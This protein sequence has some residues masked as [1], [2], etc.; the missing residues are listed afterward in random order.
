MM[1]R[2]LTLITALLLTS[3]GYHLVGH[4]DGSGVIPEDVMTVSIKAT[5]EAAQQMGSLLKRQMAG[6]DRYK[7]VAVAAADLPDELTHAE[8]RIEQASESFVPSAYDQSGLATQ[9]RM[10]IRGNVRLFRQDQKLW[11]SGV[12]TK[13][14]DV[15]V[16]GGPTGIESSRKR[17]REDLQKEWAYAAWGRINSGF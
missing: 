5:G 17:I 13:S 3:C 4:G 9:Y 12:I 14:G 2:S 16:S 1:Q 15:F 11:E 8:M 6:N 7:V 10:T